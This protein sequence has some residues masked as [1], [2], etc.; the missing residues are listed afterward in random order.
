M[1]TKYSTTADRRGILDLNM[2]QDGRSPGPTAQRLLAAGAGLGA[3][4]L[5]SI[6]PIS[7]AALDP[8]YDPVSQFISEL[9]AQGAAGAP[10]LAAGGFLP[11]GL[12]V[13]TFCTLASGLLDGS[14]RARVGF[15]FVAAVG[16]SYALTPLFPCDPGCPL[17]GST[18][19][20]V[21]TLLGMAEY[22]GFV[23]GSI[24]LAELFGRYSRWLSTYTLTSAAVAAAAI[25]LAS[26]PGNHEWRGALQ[27]IA[28]ASIFIWIGVISIVVAGTRQADA[29]EPGD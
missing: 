12:L 5:A 25:F 21:H 19:Q 29:P 4:T 6:V 14:R 8:D 2:S 18:S 22:V 27:R 11:I 20:N 1:A 16:V 3:T 17:W 10:S 28:E 9:S 15:S 13:L 23:I 26:S 7:A 24:V